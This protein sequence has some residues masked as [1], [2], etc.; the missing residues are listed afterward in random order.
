[1]SQKGSS[2]WGDDQTRFFFELTPDRVLD[3]VE[4]AG[5]RCT[6][7]CIP[8]NSLENR[9]YSVELEW[10]DDIPRSIHE[11]FRV[12][13]FYRP[14]RWSEEQIL[15]EHRFLKEL[16]DQ[17]IPVVA[18]LE[19]P[20]GVTLKK[21]ESGI[22]YALFPKVGGRSPDELNEQQLERIGRLLA[23]IHTVGAARPAPSRVHL[24]PDTYG[25]QH[26]EFLLK[27]NWVSPDVSGRYEKAVREICA[28]SRPWFQE[29]PVQRLH[30]DCHLGN[31]LWNDSGP[32]FLDFD[33][34]V[35][36]PCIQDL[37][38]VAPGRDAIGRQNFEIL[39]DAYR[40]VKEIDSRSFRLV[41]PLRALRFV[42]FS[43]WIAR[44]WEDPS[45]PNHFPQFGTPR[46]WSEVTEDL[47]EQLSFIQ[48]ENT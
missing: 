4:A 47:E 29:T 20:S 6:G 18:P 15:E 41:E 21:T 17:E 1:M 19:L 26:L 43:A 5:F 23:R 8:L 34:M 13:K 25:L 40:Q 42:H 3:A 16:L 45:F 30:G 14:S 24:N 38:L 36:G 48:Q 46:Y 37:W 2:A 7:R 35:M 33:D 31:L 27:G 22:W 9:V 11:R 12:V 32:F 44:R 39:V 28:R 10:D